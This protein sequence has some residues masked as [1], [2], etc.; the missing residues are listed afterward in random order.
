MEDV[1]GGEAPSGEPSWADR[2]ILVVCPTHRDYRELPHFSSPSTKYFFHDY[3]RTSLED[4]IGNPACRD[5]LAADPLDE[6]ETI[7]AKV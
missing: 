5:D 3:T 7:L 6:I 1:D 2:T 4:L